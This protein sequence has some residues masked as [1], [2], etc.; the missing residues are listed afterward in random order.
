VPPATRAVIVVPHPDDET[1]AA[2]GLI[3][4]ML[5]SGGSVRV[6]VLTAGDG[7][8]EAA[9]AL[10]GHDPPTPADYRAL[11]ATRA[12]EIREAMSA[13][14]VH[15]LVLLDG[16]D[17][18]LAALWTSAAPYTSPH[19][20]RGPFTRTAVL[21]ALRASIARVHPTLVVGPDP[22]DHHPD[23]A[24]AGR[25]TLAAVDGLAPRPA[26]LT[27]LVHDTVWPPPMKTG[28]VLPAPGPEYADTPWVAFRLD[29]GELA[30]KRAA[31]A[32]FRTQW[33][34]IGGLLERF[35]RDDEVFARRN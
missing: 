35:L 31:L 14:G 6:V 26:V 9:A 13:L 32:A 7:Y 5:R 18:G 28:P 27:Y 16:P 12:K 22:R 20:G 25:F 33:P 17:D 24:A 19:T 8:L 30:T 21:D 34:I 10:A 23:H 1:R 2:G 4:G 3:Q 11:G 29:P 15:D